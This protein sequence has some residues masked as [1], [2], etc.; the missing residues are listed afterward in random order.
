MVW[1][2]YLRKL[3]FS[4]TLQLQE[5]HWRK[6]NLPQ[7]S[8]SPS[9]KYL[10]LHSKKGTSPPY[11]QPKLK[12]KPLCNSL[13]LKS[14]SPTAEKTPSP[15]KTPPPFHLQL[16]CYSS[17]ETHSSLK[18]PPQVSTIHWLL[19]LHY[20]IHWRPITRWHMVPWDCDTCPKL[21]AENEPQ[22]G[23]TIIHLNPPF[24]IKHHILIK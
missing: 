9:W 13:S 23:S 17:T 18:I 15:P 22:M 3:L 1:R 10:L 4:L 19:Q 11:L 16:A 21:A 6:E 24:R 7:K 8:L 20:L 5:S 2:T 12:K 14:S